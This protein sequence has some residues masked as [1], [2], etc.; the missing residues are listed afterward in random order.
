MSLQ[1]CSSCGQRSREKLAW[2]YWAWNTAD[3]KRSGW[4]QKLC[5]ACFGMNVLPIYL[6]SMSEILQCPV[7]H[8]G[9]ES[10]YD[11]VYGTIYAP[12]QPRIDMECATC[13][14]CAVEVRNRAQVGATKLPDRRDD[15]GGPAPQLP[16]AADAWAALGLVPNGRGPEQADA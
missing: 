7:C 12:G 3:G 13:G 11:A 9:T 6:D 10:D 16:S 5:A 2:V 15:V 1:P 4:L 14:P 8:S